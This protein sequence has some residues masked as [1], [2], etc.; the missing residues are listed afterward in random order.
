MSKECVKS[1]ATNLASI[2]HIKKRIFVLNVRKA[3]IP[4]FLLDP[5]QLFFLDLGDH[6]GTLVWER[7]SRR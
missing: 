5:I 6:L 1:A 2:H 4:A 3:L 7:L